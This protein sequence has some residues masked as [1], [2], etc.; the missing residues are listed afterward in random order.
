MKDYFK[1]RQ[2]LQEAKV[3]IAKLKA[4][5]DNSTLGDSPNARGK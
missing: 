1:L 3:T 5:W 4:A 2:D